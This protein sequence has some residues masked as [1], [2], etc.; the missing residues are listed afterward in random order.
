MKISLTDSLAERVPE[1]SCKSWAG[2]SSTLH[3]TLAKEGELPLEGS[4]LAS[5]PRSVAAFLAPGIPSGHRSK[6]ESRREG[7]TEKRVL[8]REVGKR[9]EKDA[10]AL[11]CCFKDLGYLLPYLEPLPPVCSVCLPLGRKRGCVVSEAKQ[12]GLSIAVGLVCYLAS[13]CLSFTPKTSSS[14]ASPGYC[15][16]GKSACQDLT[17]EALDTLA[18]MPGFPLKPVCGSET[19][20]ARSKSMMTV[21]HLTC[22]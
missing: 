18:K 7:K 12:M 6:S 11:P 3:P 22:V 20:A 4:A 16:P 19:L 21:G 17:Q 5:A 13:L 1:P 10:Q 15:G 8:I 2:A 9:R 14:A